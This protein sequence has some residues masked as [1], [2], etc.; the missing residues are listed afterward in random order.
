M[1]TVRGGLLVARSSR[2][3]CWTVASLCGDDAYI[4]RSGNAALSANCVAISIQRSGSLWNAG[5]EHITV[6]VD[7]TSAGAAHR[8]LISIEPNAAVGRG[9]L[10]V[11][12]IIFEAMTTSWP[13]LHIPVAILY[14]TG[15][16]VSDLRDAEHGKCQQYHQGV[17]V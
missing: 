4:S 11:T 3:C 7:E 15:L 6:A 10:N 14:T 9:T 1:L 2:P 17:H 13:A 8:R 5:A 12:E 16:R